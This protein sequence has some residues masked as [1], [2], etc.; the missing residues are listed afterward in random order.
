MRAC[1]ALLLAV[2]CS[3]GPAA[4]GA[5]TMPTPEKPATAPAPAA[6]PLPARTAADWTTADLL[7]L[8]DLLAR[9]DFGV[10]AASAWI[11]GTARP[12]R[13]RRDGFEDDILDGAAA[14]FSRAVLE[15][16]RGD[17]IGVQLGFARPVVVDA[18]AL[19]GRWGQPKEGV[20]VHFDAPRQLDYEVSGPSYL[21]LL[22][23]EEAPGAVPAGQL[24]VAGVIARRLDADGMV[25]E[26]WSSEEDLVAMCRLL[27]RERPLP[28]VSLY[29]MMG[30]FGGETATEVTLTG[31]DSRNVAGGRLTKGPSHDEVPEVTGA[32]V[33]FDAPIPLDVPRFA[34]R[35]GASV[36]GATLR[37]PRGTLRLEMAAGAVKAMVFTRL[38]PTRR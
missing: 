30:V 7:R 33:R 23:L 29:G 35:I 38:P 22:Y 9:E 3:A 12:L 27:F 34:A 37:H 5:T 17:L 20:R 2:A 8:G 13:P 26:R 28:P 10:A 18:A 14:A 32:E 15:T 25:P 11:G 21:L 16:Y 31:A 24:A 36:D 1:L 19:A 6:S 4:P